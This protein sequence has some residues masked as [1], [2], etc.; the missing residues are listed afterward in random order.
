MD[1]KRVSV[2]NPAAA[3]S[4]GLRIQKL[5]NLGQTPIGIGNYWRNVHEFLLTAVRGNAKRFN[6]RDLPSWLE[7]SRGRHSAKPEQVRAMIEKASP[8]PYLELF[9]RSQP[10]RWDVWGNQI[11]Q[12]LFNR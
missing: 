3:I 1:H 10:E 9:A 5:P 12:T 8:G 4:L 6:A 7:C 2:R 11:E